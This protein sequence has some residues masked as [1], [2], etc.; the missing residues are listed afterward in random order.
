MPDEAEEALENDEG[1][2]ISTILSMRAF[3]RAKAEWD[4]YVEGKR[5][6]PKSTREP[7]KGKMIE[8]V[9]EIMFGEARKQ[10]GE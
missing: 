2:R 10:I 4:A 8:L 9:K 6:H 1:H 5:L 7:P 3:A